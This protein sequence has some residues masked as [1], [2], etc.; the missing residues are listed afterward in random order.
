MVLSAMDKNI[1]T[2]VLQGR[3]EMERLRGDTLELE[4]PDRHRDH[5]E[6]EARSAHSRYSFF[7]FFSFSRES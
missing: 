7:F 1:A 3:L 2:Q 6:L 5:A 4:L